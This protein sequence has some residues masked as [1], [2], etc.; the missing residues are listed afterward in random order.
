MENHCTHNYCL[1]T[2]LPA[3]SANLTLKHIAVGH[4]I[5][6]YTCAS[7]NAS[8]VAV[9]ALAVLWDVTP[10]YPGTSGTGMSTD[11]FDNLTSTVLWDHSIPLNLVQSQAAGPALSRAAVTYTEAEYQAVASAPW[12]SPPTDLAVTAASQPVS[13]KYLGVHYFDALSAPTFD[14]TGGTDDGLFFSGAKIGDVKAPSTA[15]TGVLSTSAVDWLELGD[16]GRGLS[17]G[18]V[19]VYRVVTAGGA[20]EA[21]SVSGVNAE[22]QVLS[23][24]YTAQYWFYG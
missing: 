2:D 1:A 23:M 8:A 5:Q 16:N 3:A 20:A 6:N 17:N 4:G 18:I 22:G 12:P 21:C 9:G 24:P 19:N 10:L 13:A 11:A 15:D 14:L 7:D